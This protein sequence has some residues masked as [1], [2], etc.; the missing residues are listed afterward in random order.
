[1]IPPTSNSDST[2]TMTPHHVEYEEHQ[3]CVIDVVNMG[4]PN[5]S[6]DKEVIPI[7]DTRGDE[8]LNGTP[9]GDSKLQDDEQRTEDGREEWVYDI[10]RSSGTKST[11]MQ[12]LLN[13]PSS[14]GIVELEDVGY[15][16]DEGGELLESRNVLNL[17]MEND[18]EWSDLSDEDDEDSNDEGYYCNDYPDGKES[19]EEPLVVRAVDSE[20]DE[21]W[22]SSDADDIHGEAYSP[23]GGVP[24][25]HQAYWREVES[26]YDDEDDL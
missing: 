8:L 5:N 16:D 18:S 14:L 15:A 2:P 24:L 11:D 9:Q 12:Q 22:M 3:F 20:T 17:I 13:E 23:Y 7:E 4:L 10:Y 19:D 26:S 25:V 6:D 21:E 1:M